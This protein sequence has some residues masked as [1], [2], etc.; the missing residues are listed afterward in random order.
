MGK[1]S[2][3]GAVINEEVTENLG[4]YIHWKKDN[5]G[6]VNPVRALDDAKK[7]GGTGRMCCLEKGPD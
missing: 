1:T 6:E 5:E 4:S 2:V 3:Q 7:Q